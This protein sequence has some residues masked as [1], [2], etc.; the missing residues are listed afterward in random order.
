MTDWIK[1]EKE[2]AEELTK[3]GYR[4]SRDLSSG[5]GD[6]NKSDI[7][8]APVSIGDRSLFFELKSSC[9]TYFAKW[10]RE[11]L[12]KCDGYHTPVIIH[13]KPGESFSDSFVYI[14]TPDFLDLIDKNND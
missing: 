12:G 4:S 7:Y 8:G 14:R 1:F 3:R 5:A 10:F 11:T 13:K 9:V 2:F 6:R